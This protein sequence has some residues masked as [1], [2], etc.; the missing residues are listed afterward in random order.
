MI[1]FDKNAPGDASRR[2]KWNDAIF[3]LSAINTK[4]LDPEN[5]YKRKLQGKCDFLFSFSAQ[6]DKI[7]IFFE[8]SFNKFCI[9]TRATI[10]AL[11]PPHDFAILKF[12]PT[13]LAQFGIFFDFYFFSR[14]LSFRHFWNFFFFFSEISLLSLIISDT[15]DQNA[16]ETH[17]SKRHKKRPKKGQLPKIKAIFE[18]KNGKTQLHLGAFFS[19]IFLYKATNWVSKES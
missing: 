11:T 9:F 19:G 13:N 6:L 10:H 2:G 14:P 1:D 18:P 7:D 17:Q 4:K 3:E 12:R 5:C 8:N 15:G 16:N